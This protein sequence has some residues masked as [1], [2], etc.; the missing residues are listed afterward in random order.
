MRRAYALVLSNGKLIR[1]LML[2]TRGQAQLAHEVWL[3]FQ[4]FGSAAYEL[5]WLM[6][7]DAA[8]AH[9]AEYQNALT[10]VAAVRYGADDDEFKM[11]WADVAAAANVV[12]SDAAA[13]SD[14]R[15]LPASWTNARA[16]IRRIKF[17]KKQ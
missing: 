14:S 11:V 12:V 6:T 16:V 15:A 2:K 8:R 9:L 7:D 10:K 3:V 17:R 1:D 5:E 4:Q 13:A